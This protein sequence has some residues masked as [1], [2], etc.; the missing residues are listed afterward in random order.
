MIQ[1]ICRDCELY[2]AVRRQSAPKFRDLLD[3]MPPAFEDDDFIIKKINL[4]G[5]L[6]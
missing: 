4:A 5:A 1:D 3:R 2:L 6:P